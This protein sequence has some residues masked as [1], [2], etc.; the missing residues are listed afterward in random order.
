MTRLPT[1]PVRSTDLMTRVNLQLAIRNTEAEVEVSLSG[2]PDD[3][4]VESVTLCD[5]CIDLDLQTLMLLMGR[6]E[7]LDFVDEA[8]DRYT[9]QPVE[10]IAGPSGWPT[11]EE[12]VYLNRK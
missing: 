4:R 12:C 11:V 3:P 2:L 7:W 5:G 10:V 8:I 6:D 9:Q 1:N